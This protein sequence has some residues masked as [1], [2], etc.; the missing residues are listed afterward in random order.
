[1]PDPDWGPS[2]KCLRIAWIFRRNVEIPSHESFY[3]R[4]GAVTVSP[5]A[6]VTRCGD[7]PETKTVDCWK[8]NNEMSNISLCF[9]KVDEW[10]K[11]LLKLKTFFLKLFSCY[12]YEFWG[13]LFRSLRP[14]RYVPYLGASRCRFWPLQRTPITL[15]NL[16]FTTVKRIFLIKRRLWREGALIG[17][18]KPSWARFWGSWARMG[19]SFGAFNTSRWQL[20]FLRIPPNVGKSDLRSQIWIV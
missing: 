16:D 8:T 13:V 19:C 10:K 3:F 14:K 12:V 2:V 4:T 18:L 11:N 15:R 6:T 9:Q 5:Q 7:S 17:D 1:M 20:R